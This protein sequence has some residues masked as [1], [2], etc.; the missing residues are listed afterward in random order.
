MKWSVQ[1]RPRTSTLLFET[2]DVFGIVARVRSAGFRVIEPIAGEIPAGMGVPALRFA[3]DA[4]IDPDGH[5]IALFQYFP[6][7][8]D[9]PRL[10]KQHGGG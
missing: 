3:E 10:L 4:V 2:D 7:D 5:V 6:N 9:W 1:E 8:A